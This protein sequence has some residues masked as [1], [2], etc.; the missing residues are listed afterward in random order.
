MRDGQAISVERRYVRGMQQAMRDYELVFIAVPTLDDEALAALTDRVTGWITGAGGTV[1][2]T[3]V[4]GRQKLAYAIRKQTEGI[5]VQ[6]NFQLVPSA[7]RDLE[8]NLQI[9]EQVMRHLV[10]RTDER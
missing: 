3:K 2:S 8:R 4:W 10:V 5:Y 1:G 7:S 9:E 6:V